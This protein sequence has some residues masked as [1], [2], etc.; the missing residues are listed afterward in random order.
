M[1][2]RIL[3]SLLIALPATALLAQ[4]PAL[5]AATARMRADLE[6]LTSAES[7]GRASLTP[8]SHAVAQYLVGRLRDAGLRPADGDAYLQR[9]DLVPLHLDRERS[10]VVV[11]RGSDEQ[12]FA[13]LS[14]AFPAPTSPVDLTL[15]VVFAGFG[16]TAPEFGYD[17]YAGLDVRGKAVLVFDHEPQEDDTRSPLH[18]AGF[19]LHANAWQKTRTAQQH[20]AAAVLLVTEPINTHRTAPRPPERANAP[21][22]ALVAGALGIPRVTL[23]ADAA[24]ALLRGTGRAPADLQRAIDATGRPASQALPGVTVSLRAVNGADATPQPSWN[25]V[26]LLPGTDPRLRDE[27]IMVTSH[28]D[29]LGVQQGR[30]YPGANDNGSGT[31]AMVEVARQLAGARLARSVLFV[32]FGSEE[33]LMLGSYHYAAHPLR[34]LPTTRAVLNLDMVGRNE[35]HT[36]ESEGA[37]EITAGRSDQLNLVGAAYSPDLAAVLRQAAPAAG[38]TLSD[39]FDR[40]SSMRT[41]FRC[42][43]LPFLQHGVPAVW[44]FGGFHPGYHEPSDTIDRVDFDKMARTVRLTVE[45]VKALAN[46]DAPPKFRY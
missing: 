10:S 13:P 28:Y 26:G 35:A 24:V 41:L 36:P 17:D 42:D 4:P 21:A 27:T 22:Q 7:A 33:Q 44:L 19:T 16:I 34:P 43:H 37:Y 31:V 38:L 23:P 1:P 20:G 11:R 30:L 18:G 45:A 25:V 32:S 5:D 8:G 3:L 9:F 2:T 29:H 40:E 12:R 15:D 14:V 6:V 39:K 46:S